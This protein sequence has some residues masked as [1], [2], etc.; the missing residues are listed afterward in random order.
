MSG[1]RTRP[2]DVDVDAFV[3]AVPNDRRRADARSLLALLREVTGE[4]PRMWGP[5]MVGFGSYP[6]TTSSGTNDW[7]WLG[8]SPRSTALTIYG[9][10]DGE[11]PDPRLAE[12]GPHTLGRSCLY[13]KKLDAVDAGLLR[14]LA[15]ESWAR[16]PH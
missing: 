11:D 9:L 12:L 2:S 6:V 3:A 5:T 8:F 13:V 10:T 14:T 4:E 15:A 1:P 7:F 16:R